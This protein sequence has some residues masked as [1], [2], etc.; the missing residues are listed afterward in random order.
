MTLWIATGN[1]K[2]KKE[3]LALLDGFPVELKTLADLGKPFEVVEDKPDFT[4]NAIKKATGLYQLTGE[5]CLADDSGLEVDDLNGEPGVYSAR[6]AGEPSDDS[7]NNQKLLDAI[8]SIE[9]PKAQ[10]HC[11]IALAGPGG[12]F[13]SEGIIRGHLIHHLQGTTGF[14]Y[15]P[16][17]VPDGYSETFAQ[18]GAEIKNKISHR[19][20]ALNLIKPI[21]LNKLNPNRSEN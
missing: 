20:Q 9:K 1:E 6:Y 19:A 13:T 14:G 11:C 10:F 21:L 18:L 5:W 15:D 2:K 4:G 7:R 12:I 8:R 17:F 3:I 16:L